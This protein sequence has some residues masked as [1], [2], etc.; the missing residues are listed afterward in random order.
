VLRVRGEV[1]SHSLFGRG[2]AQF[3]SN[4]LDRHTAH[5]ASQ[6]SGEAWGYAFK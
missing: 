5:R 1:V 6:C 2:Y 4:H 3:V